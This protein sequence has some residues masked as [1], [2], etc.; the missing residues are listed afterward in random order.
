MHNFSSMQV[1]PFVL[2]HFRKYG[3]FQKSRFFPKFWVFLNA[4]YIYNP[5][6]NR[7]RAYLQMK[8]DK[9][10]RIIVFR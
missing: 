6:E 10:I 2:A 7:V 8:L 4:E 9:I 3:D 5:G 1:E